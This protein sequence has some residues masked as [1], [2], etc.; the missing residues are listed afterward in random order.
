[1]SLK[2]IISESVFAE[3]KQS[4]LSY[5]Q[6]NYENK[7]AIKSAGGTN[8]LV[9][10]LRKTGDKEIQGAGDGCVVEPELL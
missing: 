4:G 5:G 2:E 7:G 8:A 10:L 6:Q 3:A 9:R 1:M